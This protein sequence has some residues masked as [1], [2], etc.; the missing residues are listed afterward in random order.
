[1]TPEAKEILR[2]I[3]EYLT[4]REGVTIAHAL[5]GLNIA[6]Y[7]EIHQVSTRVITKHILQDTD[8]EILE[9]MK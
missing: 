6:T 5:C 4:A 1:M 9:R 8:K 7:I 3:E 2:R